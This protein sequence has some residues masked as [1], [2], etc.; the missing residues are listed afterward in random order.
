[1]RGHAV[2]FITLLSLSMLPSC[3]VKRN[4]NDHQL[5]IKKNKI[6]LENGTKREE[7]LKS[8]L[9]NYISLKGNSSLLNSNTWVY[10]DHE[11]KFKKWWKKVFDNPPSYYDASLVEQSASKMEIFL[12]NKGYFGST[13]TYESQPK[14]PRRP[15][16]KKVTVIYTAHLTSPYRVNEMKYHIEDS[17]IRELVMPSI[18]N[19]GVRKRSRYDYYVLDQQ[20][21]NIV[22]LLQNNGYFLFHSDYIFYEIDTFF[23]NR[24]LQ[25]TLNIRPNY[26]LEGYDDNPLNQLYFKKFKIK[27]IYIQPYL[28]DIRYGAGN[29]YDTILTARSSYHN[30]NDTVYYNVVKPDKKSYIRT[31]ALLPSI[32]LEQADLYRKDEIGATRSNLVRLPALGNTFITFD[33]IPKAQYPDTLSGWLSAHI[34]I[35]EGVKQSFS[36][37]LEGTTD[38]IGVFGTSLS[39]SWS[40]RNLFKGSE[41]LTLQ[42]KGAMELQRTFNNDNVNIFG[43]FNS[44]DAGFQLSLTFPKFLAPISPYRFPRFYRPG[45][46]INIGYN[47]QYRSLYSRNLFLTSFGYK[48]KPAEKIAHSLTLLDLNLIKVDK[49]LE[50]DSLLTQYNNRRYKEQYT[51]HF[52][53]ALGYTLTF[54]NQEVGR[55]KNFTYIR[56]SIESCGNLLYGINSLFHS[57]KTFDSEKINE[58]YTLFNIRY[59]QYLKGDIEI[60]RYIYTNK[61]GA[62]L[63]FRAWGGIGVPYGNNM[64]LP[65]EKGFYGGGPNDLRGFPI[66][67]VGP[68]AYISQ[69]GNK[70]ERSGDIKLE[71]NGEYRFNISGMFKGAFFMDAGNIWLLRDDKDFTN[72]SFKLSKFYKELYWNTGLGLRLD[73]DFF[74]IRLDFGLP[75]Y[76]PGYNGDKWIVRHLHLRD[77][78]LNFGIGY[79][80]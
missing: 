35:D 2:M 4:L 40:N 73:I 76:N 71:V 15:Q 52:I 9:Q 5:L 62:N 46:S 50:F 37:D 29:R 43:I 78:V 75:I 66:N 49:T 33:T 44:F 27:D 13:V 69:S 32:Y 24:T 63:A 30:I 23:Q 70:Y 6:I 7:Y 68:G 59:A 60:R 65:F 21:S 42:L 36:V 45:T 16:N 10:N 11:T 51:D 55:N 54:S 67:I 64:S 25:V 56:T 14:K 26:R 53:M 80:F 34:N 3:S 77:I 17:T 38:N 79:P 47:F 12:Q 57:P 48:W 61:R 20:R 22:N 31:K 41:V 72:G 8:D 58:Y 74:V 39:L 19:S 1:M 18:S 28:K